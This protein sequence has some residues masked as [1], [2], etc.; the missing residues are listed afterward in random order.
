MITV[1]DPREGMLA[2]SGD[3]GAISYTSIGQ[4]ERGLSNNRKIRMLPLDGIIASKESVRTMTFPLLRPLI[5]VTKATPTG[6]AKRFID[7]SQ[8]PEVADLIRDQ[9]F[10]PNLQ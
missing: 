5:F 9:D 10:V 7:Y 1:G 3:P 6:L 8:S 2:V 4:A